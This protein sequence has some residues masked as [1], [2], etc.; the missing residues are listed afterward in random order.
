MRI[1]IGNNAGKTK[2]ISSLNKS[3]SPMLLQ[4]I[5]Y[6]TLEHIKQWQKIFVTATNKYVVT[7]LTNEICCTSMGCAV[8]TKVFLSVYAKTSNNI[9]SVYPGSVG[10][11][12]SSADQF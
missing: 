11:Q 6:A 1:D 12:R 9:V 5:L 10:I 2:I 8:L 7:I 3:N 4:Q